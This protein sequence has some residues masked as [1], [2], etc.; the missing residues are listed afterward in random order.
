MFTA[1]LQQLNI[2]KGFI[3]RNVNFCIADISLGLKHISDLQWQTCFKGQMAKKK[4]FNLGA[5]FEWSKDLFGSSI[6]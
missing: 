5:G 6:I 4:H 2:Q 3:V 1:S